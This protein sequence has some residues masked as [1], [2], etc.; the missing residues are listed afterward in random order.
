MSERVAAGDYCG[1]AEAETFLLPGQLFFGQAPARVGTLLGS[2]VSLVVW[3]PRWQLGGM[4]HFV[5]PRRSGLP[6][7]SPEG[8][9]GSEALAW[10]AQRV[11]AASTQ[12]C[13]Y[14]AWLYGGAMFG[15]AAGS[16]TAHV[17]RFEIG[18]RNIEY[19]RHECRSLGFN[20]LLEELG[21]TCYRRLLFDL[22]TGRIDLITGPAAPDTRSAPSITQAARSAQ[23][24]RAA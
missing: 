9:Y 11:N 4:C 12:P 17:R 3:H 5:L 22:S 1:G 20:V 18:E 19:A 10:L 14:L 8:R 21:G 6:P 23:Q 16:G 24:Q 13:E 15:E 7:D 2:C